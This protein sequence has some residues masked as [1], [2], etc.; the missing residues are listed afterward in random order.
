[1]TPR[2]ELAE[3][4]LHLEAAAYAAVPDAAGY[5]LAWAP[6]DDVEPAPD[7]IGV[8]RLALDV[9]AGF[10]SKPPRDH[11][12][13][14]APPPPE[15]EPPAPALRRMNGRRIA[16]EELIIGER[17]HGQVVGEQV[18]EQVVEQVVELH[19]DQ[20]DEQRHQDQAGDQRLL[21]R[22]DQRH[23]QAG[24]Q[25]GDQR[26]D[27]AGEQ[28]LLRRGEQRQ[29]Q[30]GEQRQHRTGEQHLDQAG[31]QAVEQG[32]ARHQDQAGD[33]QVGEQEGEV[34]GEQDADGVGAD[35]ADVVYARDGDQADATYAR[36]VEGV[37]DGIADV[38]YA[39]DVDQVGDQVGDQEVAGVGEQDGEQIGTMGDLLLAAA[40]GDAA[41]G[42][43]LEQALR[44]AERRGR[45]DDDLDQV[46]DRLQE[47]ATAR[48]APP[49]PPPPRRS[50]AG[51]R[52]F[53]PGGRGRGGEGEL[54]G[55]QLRGCNAGG[56]PALPGHH[57]RPIPLKGVRVQQLLPRQA[58][59]ALL[60][61][62]PLRRRQHL[63]SYPTVPFCVT[64]SSVSPP[65][66]TVAIV[67]TP[68]TSIWGTGPSEGDK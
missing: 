44:Y 46:V 3:L 50:G 26:L 56:G 21:Q 49:P 20:A 39:R 16:L 41:P 13:R 4:V 28:H 9:L 23:D 14:R 22:G 43:L 62:R 8:L 15:Q 31:E 60:S 1:M 66:V 48:R 27:Q 6:P 68:V 58:E 18:G 67:T 63:A 2:A 5:V 42:D 17:R 11:R 33:Q 34:V 45:F 53:R 32:G 36:G 54:V 57:Q 35:Q 40:L 47:V 25:Q 64:N 30:R 52:K 38:G 59:A 29:R 7:G 10:W 24:E 55:R 51:N 12:P 65:I 37:G 61:H 19:Q